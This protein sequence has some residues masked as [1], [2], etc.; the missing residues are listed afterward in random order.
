MTDVRSNRLAP[1]E[2]LEQQVAQGLR[3]LPTARVSGSV[4]EVS[5]SHYRVAGLSRFLKLG[6]CVGVDVGDR[7][8]IGEVVRIDDSSATLKPFD[9]RSDVT[10]GARAFR[11]ET[12]SLS[13]HRSWR[14]RVVDA[15]GRPIDGAGEL[16]HGDR[17]APLD[18]SPPPPLRLGPSG[19]RRCRS[20]HDPS[21]RPRPGRAERR[22]CGGRAL[23]C[24][25]DERVSPPWRV[26]R[27]ASVGRFRH[28][29][30]R[31]PRGFFR[32]PWPRRGVHRPVARG[33]WATRQP[34][35]WRPRTRR[36]PC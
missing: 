10:I 18:A 32:A 4:V 7:V 14:G 11:T 16:P 1:L 21:A 26:Y 5:T 17:P 6:E 24:D 3:T 20:A 31:P 29:D 15:L 33:H 2:R 28:W 27:E 36:S 12:L 19:P 34:S 25:L 8:E 22:R 23:S 13:P 35:A 30:H 9:T